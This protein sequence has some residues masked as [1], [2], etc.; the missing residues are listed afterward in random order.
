MTKRSGVQH[1]YPNEF[2]RRSLPMLVLI[3][4]SLL[5]LLLCTACG[6]TSPSTTVPTSSAFHTTVQTTDKTFTVQITI[7]PNKLGNNTFMV[8]LLP[9]Q[10]QSLQNIQVNLQTT[11]LD[12]AMGTDSVTLQ[13]DNKGN[14]S[15]QGTLTMSGNW[16]IRVVIH[17]PDH[18][19]HEG[20]FQAKLA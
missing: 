6:G 11:M 20:Q 8:T 3:P 17:T 19:L 15:G 10:Q 16:Q 13:A 4:L 5:L 1:V 14:Y 12:M 2:L 9:S 18:T 7:T